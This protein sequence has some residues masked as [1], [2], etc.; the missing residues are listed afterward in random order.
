MSDHVDSA[1]VRILMRESKHAN[2]TGLCP[3]KY[4][5]HRL[6]ALHVERA[7]LLDFAREMGNEACGQ[8]ARKHGGHPCAPNCL[9]KRFFDTFG[10]E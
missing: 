9:T 5:A 6:D 10:R 1:L 4:A 7:S 2:L 3:F 8:C